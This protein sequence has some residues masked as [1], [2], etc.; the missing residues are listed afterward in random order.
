M[1]PGEAMMGGGAD[2]PLSV[3]RVAAAIAAAVR[4]KDP[5]LSESGTAPAAPPRVLPPL[6]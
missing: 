3:R 6:S 5:L 2:M 4:L 1:L